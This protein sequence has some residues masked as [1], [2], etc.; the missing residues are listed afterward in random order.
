MARVQVS[1][2]VPA[3]NAA[4][5]IGD[6]LAALSTQTSS[7]PWEVVVV[8][9]GSSDSTVDIVNSWTPRLPN[10]RVTPCS[11]PGINSARNAGVRA[12]QGEFIVLTDADDVV[13]AGWLEAMASTLRSADVVGGRLETELLN[14]AL[15]SATRSNPVSSSLPF[16][17]EFA[18]AV[19]AS[20][21]FRR[22]VFEQ[23]GGFDEHF[24]K[25][26]GDDVDFCLR[27]QYEGFRIGFASGAVTH[28]RFRVRLR[29]YYTQYLNYEVGSAQC[30][31]KHVALGRLPRQV[32]SKQ[33]HVLARRG[34]T[35]LRVDRLVR[36]DDR[37]R[38]VRRVA[39]FVG[40][41]VSFARY[42]YLA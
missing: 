5:T 40:S 39:V 6:A 29:D 9:N 18:Y 19:G 42:R 41:L 7:V 34:R 26:G 30:G 21:G 27:A 22:S 14:P 31:A 17:G 24:V 32:T 8:D 2:V 12:A 25:G 23:I 3:R 28:Y 13:S 20:L 37:W 35:V 4:S 15:V 36:R 11:R 10:L 1:V 33:L 38:Y 16:F